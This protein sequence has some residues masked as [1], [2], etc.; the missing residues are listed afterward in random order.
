MKFKYQFATE[1]VDVE[2]D[3]EWGAI[4]LDLDR[5]EYNNDQTETRRHA[6]LNAMDY[7]G[8]VFIN[9]HTDISAQVELSETQEALRRAMDS[10]LP[11]QKALLKKVFF[12][13]IPAAEI[14]RQEGVNKSS[15]H[16]R[17]Q[18]IFEQLKKVLP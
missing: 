3:E 13:G 9:P 4:L 7:E 18:R 1:A 17:L 11:Q 5:R 15:V 6:S 16:K 8:E 12:E 10:L 2:V 14:A